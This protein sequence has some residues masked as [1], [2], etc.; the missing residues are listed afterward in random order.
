MSW[1][2]IF[3]YTLTRTRARFP[4]PVFGS[5][6]V[7]GALPERLYVVRDGVVVYQGGPGPDGYDVLGL[8]DFVAA[9]SRDRKA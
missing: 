1:L 6:I 7:Y 8:V 3:T 5:A 2:S 9:A 4:T